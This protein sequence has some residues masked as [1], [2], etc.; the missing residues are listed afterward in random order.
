MQS[1]HWSSTLIN[2]YFVKLRRYCCKFIGLLCVYSL[3]LFQ[4]SL[5]ISVFVQCKC[6]KRIELNILY[7]LLRFS[8]TNPVRSPMP[9]RPAISPMPVRPAR[10][11]MPVR[12]AR[13]PMPSDPPDRA[14]PSDPPYRPCPSDP[15][16]L[17]CPSDPRQI[18]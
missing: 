18:D 16:Y 11:P 9:V 17:P 3:I 5:L 1:K 13:S 10:S 4:Y 8:F 6:N 7:C 15:P 14:C 2:V 12:P